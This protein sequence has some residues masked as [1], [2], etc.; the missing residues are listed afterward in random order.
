M[1][2][3]VITLIYPAM[4]QCKKQ[5]PKK[6]ILRMRDM[7]QNKTQVETVNFRLYFKVFV[8]QMMIT[9][10]VN[11]LPG[12]SITL[13]SSRSW[14]FA[15][16]N[17]HLSDDDFEISIGNYTVREVLMKNRTRVWRNVYIVLYT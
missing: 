9:T 5:I 4:L 7:L 11:T 14:W 6:D 1:A 3:Y 16:T 15:Q 8:R 12:A 13:S 17:H 2:D 10:T